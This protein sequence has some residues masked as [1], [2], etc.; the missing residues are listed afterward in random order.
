MKSP[1]KSRD[2]VHST[3]GSLAMLIESFKGRGFAAR[4]GSN[5]ASRCRP[6]S[7]TR[8]FLLR[9]LDA[10][11]KD[12]VGKSVF[13][14]SELTLPILRFLLKDD[15]TTEE[16]PYLQQLIWNYSSARHIS[17]TFDAEIDDF[18]SLPDGR[19][20]RF[21]ETL[22]THEMES[23]RESALELFEV[24]WNR[25]RLR[26]WIISRVAKHLEDHPQRSSLEDAYLERLLPLLKSKAKA[27]K[28]KP[29]EKLETECGKCGAAQFLDLAPTRTDGWYG[30]SCTECKRSY[31]FH[32]VS[33]VSLSYIFPPVFVTLF[34]INLPLK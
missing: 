24:S 18:F 14:T 19:L 26:P 30:V 21:F 23:L 22:L 3:H 12:D 9:L 27:T 13:A 20:E 32:W 1:S 25:N 7:E 15:F 31:S 28:K 8:E 2:F 34:I 11:A 6:D 10:N 33:L 16:V 4:F 5:I 29:K 17:D